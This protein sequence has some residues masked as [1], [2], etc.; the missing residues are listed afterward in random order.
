LPRSIFI[1][2]AVP[3]I[4]YGSQLLASVPQTPNI[5]LSIDYRIVCA[6]LIAVF[7]AISAVR[8]TIGA[9]LAAAL[10]SAACFYVLILSW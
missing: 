2:L 3:L 6:A 10:L 4:F 9:A 8:R 1:A 7:T 5:T